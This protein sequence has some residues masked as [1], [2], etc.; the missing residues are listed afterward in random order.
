[1]SSFPFLPR[2][3]SL[4]DRHSGIY[5]GTGRC[6]CSRFTGITAACNVQIERSR[7]TETSADAEH[8]YLITYTAPADGHDAGQIQQAIVRK[9]RNPPRLLRD[10]LTWDQVRNSPCTSRSARA[11]HAGLFLRPAPPWRRGTNENTNGLL[12]Q[13]SPK[14]TD[15][16]KYPEDHLD[17]V[18]EELNDRPRKT[19]GHMKPSEKILELLDTAS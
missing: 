5:Q 6:R 11:G 1:M 2:T 16:S 10:S 18:A 19:L 14:G 4:V 8:F 9:M 17:A 12:R 3:I 15:P 13:Y 7:C